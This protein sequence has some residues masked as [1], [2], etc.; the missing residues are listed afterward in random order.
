MTVELVKVGLA[1]V[2]DWSVA[3]CDFA[4]QLR[5]T[6][7]EAKAK[8]LRIWRDYVAPNAGNDMATFTARVVEIVSGDTV[9]RARAARPAARPTARPP[10]RPL[11]PLLRLLPPR[12][13]RRV[14]SVTTRY[15]R[16][17]A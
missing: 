2:V 3:Y 10:P 6:E 4:P 12:A 17:A 9:V 11:R 7:R 5:T 16:R 15:C 13:R 1:R 8:R 14:H